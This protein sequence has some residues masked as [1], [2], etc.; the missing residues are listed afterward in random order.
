MNKVKIIYRGAA[1]YGLLVLFPM[2]FMEKKIGVDYPP[3]ITHPDF[4][5]GF[6]FVA[7]VFQFLFLVIASDPK[8]FRPIILISIFEK[9]PYGLMI[10]YLYSIERIPAINLI[11]GSVDLFLGALFV[12]SYIKTRD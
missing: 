2:L 11:G 12:W 5:Y 4:F 8:R 3:P 9:I 10:I 7:L 1:I 6:I